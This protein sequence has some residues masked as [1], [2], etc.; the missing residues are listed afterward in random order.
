MIIIGISGKKYSGKTTLAK[1]IAECKSDTVII[2]F[3][4]ALKEEVAKA[5]DVTVEFIEANKKDF[6]TI[7][8]WWGTDFR[9]KFNK[10]NY[11]LARWIQKCKNLTPEPKLVIA[12]DVRFKNEADLVKQLGG[13]LVRVERITNVIDNHPSETELD[14]YKFDLVVTNNGTLEELRETVVTKIIKRK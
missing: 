9:R 2:N 10:D 1:V 14:D 6:R 5:C 3:A 7:L 13:Y 8:Q 4:D 12:A 11:W